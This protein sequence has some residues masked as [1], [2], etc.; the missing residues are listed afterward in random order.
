MTTTILTVLV[1][2]LATL[3]YVG[4]GF[5]LVHWRSSYYAADEA[6]Q[7]LSERL[8][9]I[10]EEKAKAES[11]LKVFKD[12]LGVIASRQLMVQLTDEQVS[13]ITHQIGAILTPKEKQ[14]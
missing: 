7:D 13:F 11:D 12:Y 9:L 8:V 2:V 3:G 1:T 10:S 5:R 4:L 6:A 14:N